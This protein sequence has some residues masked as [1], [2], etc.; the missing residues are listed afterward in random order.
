M[1]ARPVGRKGAV[2]GHGAREE[3][4]GAG[5]AAPRVGAAVRERAEHSGLLRERAHL[6][7]CVLP[8]SRTACVCASAKIAF[9][10]A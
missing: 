7:T 9:A 5:V 2:L 4:G 8:E 3:H 1:A 6:N 10:R